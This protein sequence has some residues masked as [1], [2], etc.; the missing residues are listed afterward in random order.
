MFPVVEERRG[1][2]ETKFVRKMEL[3][4][5]LGDGHVLLEMCW[6]LLQVARVLPVACVRHQEEVWWLLDIA[7][8]RSLFGTRPFVTVLLA[9]L[10]Q[11]QIAAD[12]DP[13]GE[14]E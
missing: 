10:H 4:A 8:S 14:F 9:Q 2:L 13:R 3:F 6:G 7:R 12:I 11:V 1:G 5:Q